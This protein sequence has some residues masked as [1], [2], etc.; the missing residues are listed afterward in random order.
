M[1][2]LPKRQLTADEFQAWALKQPRDGHGKFELIDGY[3]VMQEPER[4]VHAEVK[5]ALFAAMRDAIKSAGR[6]CFAVVDEPQI[7]IHSKKVYQPDGLVYCGERVPPDVLVNTPVIVWEV[8]SPGSVE[9]DCGDKLEAYFTVPS[10]HHYLIVDPARRAIIHHRRRQQ[11]E[12]LTR[13]RR[14]GTLKF[15][16]PG[17]EVNVADVFER[18]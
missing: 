15:F 13:V 7:R 9:R 3:V 11:D 12:L 14:S 10:L 8:L 2:V 5:G 17:L 16:P 6:P 18:F 1:T 4:A